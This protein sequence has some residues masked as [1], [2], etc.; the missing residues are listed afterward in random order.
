VTGANVAITGSFTIA[1]GLVPA[2]CSLV[3]HAD[4]QVAAGDRIVLNV[5]ETLPWQLLVQPVNATVDDVVK[6]RVCNISGVDFDAGS[7]TYA[8]SYGAIR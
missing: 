8:L 3:T 6:V 7:T 1:P 2:G 4:A 5:D